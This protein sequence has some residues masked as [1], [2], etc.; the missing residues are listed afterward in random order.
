[1]ICHGLLCSFEI[2]VLNVPNYFLIFLYSNSAS[3]IFFQYLKYEKKSVTRKI[4]SYT[5]FAKHPLYAGH[6][7][8]S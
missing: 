7:S 6:R 5:T 3:Q 1:M 4:S 2:K 8:T